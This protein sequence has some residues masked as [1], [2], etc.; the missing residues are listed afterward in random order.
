MGIIP[1]GEIYEYKF[2]LFSY[3]APEAYLSLNLENIVQNPIH[4][5]KF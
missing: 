5:N 3:F 2:N 4:C 1:N